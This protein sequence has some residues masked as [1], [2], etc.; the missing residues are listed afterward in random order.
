MNQNEFI[1]E[2]KAAY[3]SAV[4]RKEEKLFQFS[5]IVWGLDLTQDK[6]VY[7]PA[8]C[9]GCTPSAPRQHKLGA[10]SLD[11]DTGGWIMLQLMVVFSLFATLSII[12]CKDSPFHKPSSNY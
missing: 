12:F 11:A 6:S 2:W 5:E 10:V 7:V 3:S 4:R 8:V 1:S 9:A